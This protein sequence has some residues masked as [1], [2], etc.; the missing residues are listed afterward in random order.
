METLTVP[1]FLEIFTEEE[2]FFWDG[3]MGITRLSFVDRKAHGAFTFFDI[4]ARYIV[5]CQPL[6]TRF[7]FV[8]ES[9]ISY[10]NFLCPDERKKGKPVCVTSLPFGSSRLD[11]ARTGFRGAA[12]RFLDLDDHRLFRTPNGHR[13][14]CS[15]V[16]HEFL[17]P[18]VLMNQ[19]HITPEDCM[20]RCC[21]FYY[22]THF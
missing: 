6:N 4:L 7:T 18:F 11:A 21:H 5:E 16:I 3:F 13:N 20:N 2:I 9:L 8:K 15:T 12:S 1:F 17:P 19:L 22:T 14:P 10:S